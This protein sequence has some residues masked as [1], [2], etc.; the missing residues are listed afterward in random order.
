MNRATP[1][2]LFL[3]EGEVLSGV[4]G[5]PPTP[6]SGFLIFVSKNSLFMKL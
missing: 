2:T 6:Y 3:I 5:F 1:W 4:G